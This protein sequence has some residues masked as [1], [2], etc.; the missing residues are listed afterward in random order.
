MRRTIETKG[1]IRGK[2]R[3]LEGGTN[4][5]MFQIKLKEGLPRTKVFP[6]CLKLSCL[7]YLIQIRLKGIFLDVLPKAGFF[8][9]NH[10]GR[11]QKVVSWWQKLVT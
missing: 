11:K 10:L 1:Q 5:T 4:F 8:C 9:L 2:N 3:V 6:T 7:L